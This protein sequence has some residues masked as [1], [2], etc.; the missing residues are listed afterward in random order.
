MDPGFR[1]PPQQAALPNP[2]SAARP[3]AIV[4][5]TPGKPGLDQHHLSRL[6]PPK[7]ISTSSSEWVH[8]GSGL[9]SRD[10]RTAVVGLPR[11]GYKFI[12]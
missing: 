11:I 7:K 1:A 9:I 10:M 4:S 6:A 5:G 8:S 12:A 2:M 3:G